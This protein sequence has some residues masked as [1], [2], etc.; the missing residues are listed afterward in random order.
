MRKLL[1]MLLLL[2][3]IS[4]SNY[5]QGYEDGYEGEEKNSW[6]VIGKDEYNSGYEE[7]AFDSECEDLKKTD[8]QKYLRWGCADN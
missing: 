7:G 4:C 8:Y 5:D 2:F 1:L 3:P 6:V